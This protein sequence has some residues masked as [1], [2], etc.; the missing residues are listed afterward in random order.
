[1]IPRMF[2]AVFF[3]SAAVTTV[4]LIYWMGPWF[5]AA[6]LALVVIAFL[7]SMKADPRNDRVRPPRPTSYKTSYYSEL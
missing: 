3:I 6:C 2:R 1:M 5:L 4:G 7:F